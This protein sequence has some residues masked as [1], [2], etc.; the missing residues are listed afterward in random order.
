MDRAVADAG[1]VVI[2]SGLRRSKVLI[3][4]RALGRLPTASVIDGLA[5]PVG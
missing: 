5:N 4:G 3:D 2:G 1:S